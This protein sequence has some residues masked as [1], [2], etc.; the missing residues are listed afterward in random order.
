MKRLCLLLAVLL[1]GTL[2]FGQG[3]REQA[4][5]AAANHWLQLT[6]AGD[7]GASW[8]Q[9]APLFKSSIT[10]ERWSQ[11]LEATRTPL[12]KVVSRKLIAAKYTTSL[13][14]VPDGEYV[15]I[16]FEAVFANKAAAIET[17]TPTLTKD[18]AW[19]VCGY[20]IH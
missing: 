10:R 15:V 20:Y 9:A 7:Y 16:Q 17:V 11:A 18:G 19:R 12:G 2:A 1:L 14:G 13:P 3:E 4:A 5:V 6:D 8:Q